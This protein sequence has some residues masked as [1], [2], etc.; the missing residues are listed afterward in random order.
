MRGRGEVGRRR[1]YQM[2]VEVRRVEERRSGGI[3]AAASDGERGK[4]ERKGEKGC[5]GRS[6]G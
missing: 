5:V 4:R 2:E 1:R 3:W 6:G